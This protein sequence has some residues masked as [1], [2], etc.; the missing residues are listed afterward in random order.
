MNETTST[1][2]IDMLIS[3]FAALK[4]FQL[5]RVWSQRRIM[6][7]ELRQS[8]HGIGHLMHTTREISRVAAPAAVLALDT[9][10]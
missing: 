9:L 1:S 10:V 3:A 8:T 6:W 7:Q 5:E 4:M 2:F